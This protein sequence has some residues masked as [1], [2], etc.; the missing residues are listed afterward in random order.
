[1]KW[2]WLIIVPCLSWA[3][4]NEPL[5]VALLTGYRNDRLHWHTQLEASDH[6]ITYSEQY[7]DIQFWE[8]GLALK[9]IHRDLVFF[10]SGSYAAFGRGGTLFDR[11]GNLSFTQANP[12]FQFS[13][14]G[15]AS[16]A[17]GYFG[18]AV[19]LTPDRTYKTI[20][21]PLVGYSA[22]FERLKRPGSSSLSSTNAAG[23]ASF[24]MTPELPQE[25]H[26]SMYGVLL[27]VGF[28]VEPGGNLQLS[29]GYTYH[30]LGDKFKTHYGYDVTLYDA[31]G[32]PT[33]SSSTQIKLTSTSS[34]N[35][36]Q[37]GWLELQTK[38]PK[39]WRFGLAAMIHYFATRVVDAR[40]AP[41]GQ[42]VTH[43]KFR[44]R[45]TPISG[46][47]VVSKEL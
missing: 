13:T 16:D 32:S 45:W 1:M 22:H 18:Y 41:V 37:T 36:G 2:L 20:L 26:Q 30:W 17:K 21:I 25:L 44:L 7:R 38:L 19:N 8:N 39:G 12:R 23:A 35:L 46:S 33:S 34:G 42:A 15:W 29:G 11:F 40:L 6:A 43:Q 27:G 10:L 24:T 9:V 5:Q 4:V 31:S 28:Q 3:T 47:V 14:Q